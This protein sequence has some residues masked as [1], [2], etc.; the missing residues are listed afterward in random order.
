[1]TRLAGSSSSVL[2][3]CPV[4]RVPPASVIS[5]ISASVMRA[6]PPCTTGQPTVCASIPSSSAKA[7]VPG[8]LSG[9]MECAARPASI[10]RASLVWKPRASTVAGHSPRRPKPAIASGWAGGV[11]SGASTVGTI[12]WASR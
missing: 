3:Q 8:A 12:A 7:L 6:L 10:A 9:R 4:C 2:T 11:S 1:M 5:A